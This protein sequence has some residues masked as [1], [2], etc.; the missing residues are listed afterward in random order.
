MKTNESLSLIEYKSKRKNNLLDCLYAIIAAFL[1]MIPVVAVM[2]GAIVSYD[3]ENSASALILFLFLG[4]G[5]YVT[6]V[7]FRLVY[8]QFEESINAINIEREN[9]LNTADEVDVVSFWKGKRNQKIWTVSILLSIVVIIIALNIATTIKTDRIYRS[10]EEYI[11]QEKYE[12]ALV[13][14][15]SIKETRHKDTIS[16]ITLCECYIDYEKGRGADAYYDLKNAVFHWQNAEQYSNIR[17]FEEVLRKEHNESIKRMAENARKS[18]EEKK[19]I[20]ETEKKTKSK[21]TYVPKYKE[22]KSD[23]YNAKD[24]RNEEDFY[25]DHY[26]DFFDYYDA[27]KYY[28]EHHD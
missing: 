15:E 13:L 1:M 22:D 23:P 7:I 5:I 14:L 16:L 18:Y 3:V 26:D 9:F 21:S 11:S 4:I 25:D 2:Y 17:E 19:R 12:E 28:R 20:E 6:G 27:E 8:K 24:Y 10:A